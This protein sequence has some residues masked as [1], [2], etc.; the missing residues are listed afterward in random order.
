MRMPGM[1]RR[2]H[3]DIPERT[4]HRQRQGRW[5]WRPHGNRIEHDL[6]A[7]G[8]GCTSRRLRLLHAPVADS[9]RTVFNRPR[10]LVQRPAAFERALSAV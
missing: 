4:G 6:L 2:S 9:E 8:F 3:T 5:P 10:L 1:R 7:P